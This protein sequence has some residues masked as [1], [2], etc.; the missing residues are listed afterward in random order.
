[1]LYFISKR[2]KEEAFYLPSRRSVSAIFN[3]VLITVSG[4]SEMLSIPHS[5]RN[6]ANSG[7]SEGACPQIPTFLR[8]W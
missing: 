8:G 5:T 6:S 1:M 2:E 7:K 3:L 4:F